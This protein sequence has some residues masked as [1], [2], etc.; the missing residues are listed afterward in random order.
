MK[1]ETKLLIWFRNL[2]PYS[3]KVRQRHQVEFQT[4]SFIGRNNITVPLQKG[5]RRSGLLTA[6]ETNINNVSITLLNVDNSTLYT[7]GNLFVVISI[8]IIE[9]TFYNDYIHILHFP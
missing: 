3:S 4:F 9:G 6:E 5:S 8:P 1:D 7:E 2:P